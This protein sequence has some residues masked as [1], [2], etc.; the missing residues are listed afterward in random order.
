V[1]GEGPLL[2]GLWTVYSIN[3]EDIGVTLGLGRIVALHRRSF[4][5]HQ[6]RQQ[7]WYLDF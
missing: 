4:S 6:I 5:S 7:I 3:K 2:D 1:V